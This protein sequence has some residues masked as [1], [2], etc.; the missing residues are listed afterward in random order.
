MA[1]NGNSVIA[2][3]DSSIHLPSPQTR[4]SSTVKF[5]VI[6]YGYWGPNL[7]RNFAEAEDCQVAGIADARPERLALALRRHPGVGITSNPT[8]L[9]RNPNIDAIAVDTSSAAAGAKLVV[10]TAID[11]ATS[12]SAERIPTRSPAADSTRSGTAITKD[13]LIPPHQ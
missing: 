6:G 1:T 3:Y 9:L 7:A 11:S 10:G 2:N 4:R 8:E 12:S 5:G 13:M